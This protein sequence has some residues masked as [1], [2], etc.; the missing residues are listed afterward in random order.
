M[1]ARGGKILVVL[2]LVLATGLHWTALQTVAWTTMLAKNLSTQSF[3]AA[4]SDT[5]DGRH[6]CPLCQAISKGRQSEQ[7]SAAVAPVRVPEP[8]A[9]ARFTTE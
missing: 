3:S 2:A 1:F 6:P 4:V 5:F 7:K 8:L 9:M